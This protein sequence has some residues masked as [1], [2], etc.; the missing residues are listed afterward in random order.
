V[1]RQVGDLYSGRCQVVEEITECGDA[2]AARHLHRQRVRIGHRGVAQRG[3]GG[4]ERIGGT[5]PQQDAPAGNG[6]LQIVRCSL[7]D[8]AAAV[9]DGDPAGQRISFLQVL[10]GEEDRHPVL[11][12]LADD[13]PQVAAA[14]RVEPGRWFVQEDQPRTPD[15]RHRE[16]EAPAHAT[17]VGRRR[18]AR[19]VDEAERRQELG[20]A[21]LAV[22]PAQV[23]KV[24]HQA[25]V[26]L[27][28]EQ[29]VHGGELASHADRGPDRLGLA[30]EVV[31]H[32]A[33]VAAICADQRGQD[34]H[35][36]GLAGTVRAEEREDRP[37][38]DLQVDAV[39]HDLVAVGLPESAHCNGVLICHDAIAQG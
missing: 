28:G 4:P 21:P 23:V 16:V 7:G 24:G 32:D 11:D 8:D 19:S 17:G 26:L 27:A 38:G 5:E 33:D 39:K 9:E 20:C 3:G 10:R 35:H 18:L 25:E 1:D 36:G 22:V 13:A 15:Q 6:A 34:L 12:K 29:G 2:P 14:S 37:G 31:I 30:G